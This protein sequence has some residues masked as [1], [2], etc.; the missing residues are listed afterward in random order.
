MQQFG[1]QVV[2]VNN[3]E[4]EIQLPVSKI[5]ITFRCISRDTVTPSSLI[6]VSRMK[7]AMRLHQ[8]LLLPAAQLE[9]MRSL[10]VDAIRKH[11]LESAERQMRRSAWQL[12]LP[13]R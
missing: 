5:T 10:G 11:R 7:P 8:S 1:P 13:L 4:V 2:W 12:F 9:A 6:E 3:S